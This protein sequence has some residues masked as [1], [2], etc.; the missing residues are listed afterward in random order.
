MKHLIIYISFLFFSFG[1]FAQQDFVG[2]QIDS[3]QISKKKF[4]SQSL[5]K[6]K[7]SGDFNYN[8]QQKEKNILQ[9]IWEWLGRLVKKVLSWLF[10]DI[11]PALGLIKDFLS[12][13][14]YILLAVLLYFILKFFLKIDTNTLANR[15]SKIAS[16]NITDEEELIKNSDL[17]DLVNQSVINKNYRLAVR[18][19]YL[20]IL[21]K[22]A[23]KELIIWQQ[24]K[25][26]EDYIKE[27][28][29]TKVHQQFTESTRLYD[30]VWY[31]NFNINETEFT[32]AETLFTN[33]KSKI[34]E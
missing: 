28:Q 11:S 20:L 7:N 33:L 25:T 29:A 2:I 34:G 1:S 10:D 19:Y 6:Y 16:I 24:E 32:K 30:F 5:E 8:V 4:D 13:L 23:D 18:Y 26:N 12:I 14:P 31:G 27:L 21:Q 9:R 3:T 22:L 15:N 17:Q